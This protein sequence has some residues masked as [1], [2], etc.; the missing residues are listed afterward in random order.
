MA[1]LQL[2]NN[3]SRQ[4]LLLLGGRDQEEPC[5]SPLS[6]TG[7]SRGDSCGAATGGGA[8]LL[9][10]SPPDF[11]SSQCQ[12]PQRTI[13][14]SNFESSQRCDLSW[15][16]NPLAQG[17]H[18][19]Q[20]DGPGRQGS[21]DPSQSGGRWLSPRHGFATQPPS[22]LARLCHVTHRDR[23]GARP[24]PVG[25]GTPLAGACKDRSC[26]CSVWSVLPDSHVKARCSG[27]G[28]PDPSRSGG[29][30][31]ALPRHG[32]AITGHLALLG[33]VWVPWQPLNGP[34]HTGPWRSGRC[35]QSP[36]MAPDQC[37]C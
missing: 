36:T 35:L 31:L 30:S 26:P 29:R 11:A 34:A 8:A 20:S 28:S 2:C 4:C 6:E 21:G 24:F 1:S 27:G 23:A 25:G 33:L 16:A 3:R 13:T 5:G 18:P 10:H 22:S 9:P 19:S 15:M 37:L 14:V 12:C 17:K 7:A 32:L